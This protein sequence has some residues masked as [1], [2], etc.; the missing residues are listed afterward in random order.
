MAAGVGA[1]ALL[2]GCIANP[3][4]DAIVDPRSPIAA[5][6]TKTVNPDAPYPTFVAFPKTP[7][8]VRPNPQ[9]GVVAGRVEADGAQLIAAT[10]DS[11]WTLSGTD[12]FAAQV[13]AAA[14]P[15]LPPPAPGDTEAFAK[16]LK[17]RATP[18]PP[19]KR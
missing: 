3:F 11:T 17:A 5:E 1:C 10:A 12:A 13:R 16:D 14:G 6:V 2:S 18:P 4:K 7:E 8:G 15:L 9:Y 19:V